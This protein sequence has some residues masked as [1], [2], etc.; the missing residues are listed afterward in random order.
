MKKLLPFVALAVVIIVAMVLVVQNNNDNSNE[1]SKTQ[2][3][4]TQKNPTTKQP[5]GVETKS[6][7]ELSTNISD[8]TADGTA[9]KCTYTAT[10]ASGE[11]AGTIYTDG[12]GKSRMTIA[13][14]SNQG[15]TGTTDTILRDGK[16]Y[17]WITSAGNTFGFSGDAKTTTNSTNTNTPPTT[18]NNAPDISQ[19]FAMKCENWNVDQAKFTVPTN[20]NFNSLPTGVP[21]Q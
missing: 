21:T 11:G 13:L 9:R 2:N 3:T 17:T 18:T 20:V 15:N 4:T 1:I 7:G 5:T 6:Q 12:K 8:L 14:A 16:Y 10:T 19:N